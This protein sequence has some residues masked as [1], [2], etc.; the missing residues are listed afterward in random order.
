VV[1][2]CVAEEYSLKIMSVQFAMAFACTFHAY[3]R[4]KNLEVAEVGFKLIEALKRCLFSCFVHKAVM[5]HWARVPWVNWLMSEEFDVVPLAEALIQ[6]NQ[7][8]RLPGLWGIKGGKAGSP[9]SSGERRSGDDMGMGF[10]SILKNR[11]ADLA[12][13]G[14]VGA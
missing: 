9:L 8:C 6:A 11:R 14:A 1:S 13:N 7:H 5:E 12:D 2:H 4:A 3:P 10:N